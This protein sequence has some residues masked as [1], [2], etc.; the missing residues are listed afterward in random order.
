MNDDRHAAS[1]SIESRQ[2]TK[3]S[4]FEPFSTAAGAE[5]GRSQLGRLDILQSVAML[6]H[7]SEAEVG[8]LQLRLDIPQCLSMQH[9]GSEAELGRPQL[10]LD[11]LQ[12]MPVLRDGSEAELGRLIRKRHMP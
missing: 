5:L 9:H 12:C 6:R 7:G 10:R 2:G 1:L 4:A 3:S 11:I 8:C